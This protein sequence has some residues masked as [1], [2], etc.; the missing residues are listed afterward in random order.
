MLVLAA[1]VALGAAPFM[2]DRA[3][4]AAAARA[5]LR[6]CG[7]KEKAALEAPDTDWVPA[8]SGQA[9]HARL[10][11]ALG[12]ALPT[13]TPQILIFGGGGDLATVQYSVTL[14]RDLQ[15]SWRFDAFGQ[16]RISVQDTKPRTMN[17]RSGTIGVDDG[18]RLDA[19]LADRCFAA[20]P[21]LF[22][23]F[24]R[25]APPPIGIIVR[26]VEATSADGERRFVVLGDAS[27]LSGELLTIVA[28]YL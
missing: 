15:G 12:I 13:T 22:D 23:S 25:K 28:K 7:P 21:T 10:R 19:I 18:R 17:A 6:R 1:A 5:A 11:A 26:T 24:D 8:E 3:S 4:I 27:G 20:E 14:A 9:E 16:S 2:D